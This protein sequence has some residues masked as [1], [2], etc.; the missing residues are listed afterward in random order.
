MNRFLQAVRRERKRAIRKVAEEQL[1]ESFPSDFEALEEI[2][3]WF[4][5]KFRDERL[6][7]RTRATMAQYVIKVIEAK[8]R[9]AGLSDDSKDRPVRLDPVDLEQY[10]AKVQVARAEPGEAQQEAD[11]R[12]SVH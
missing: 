12:R 7:L 4:L 3:A 2:K 6:E 11:E 1:N 10:L 5:K 9:L 8:V